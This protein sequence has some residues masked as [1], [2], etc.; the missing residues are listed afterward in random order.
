MSFFNY[1]N[2]LP[3]RRSFVS[4]A[5]ALQLILAFGSFVVGLIAL[6][7]ELIKFHDQRKK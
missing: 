4:V 6:V 1:L 3:E 5:D 2:T 7:V